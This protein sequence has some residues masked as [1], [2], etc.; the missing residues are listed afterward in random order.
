MNNRNPTNVTINDLSSFKYKS[1]IL[2]KPAVD[3]VLKMQK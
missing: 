1:N 2:Q 3:G